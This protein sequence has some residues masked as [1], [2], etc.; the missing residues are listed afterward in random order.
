[1][2]EDNQPRR[3]TDGLTDASL[4]PVW[5]LYVATNFN[6]TQLCPGI[7]HV[8]SN[9]TVAPTIPMV[10]DDD[11][12]A[13]LELDGSQNCVESSRRIAYGAQTVTVSIYEVSKCFPELGQ[14]G[15]HPLA[16]ESLGLRLELFEKFPTPLADRI[17]DNPQRSVIQIRNIFR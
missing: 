11:F 17:R 10:S 14:P 5:L 16:K 6:D 12:V 2:I 3:G 1:V 15:G 7:L 4:Y 8:P 13:L 9:G